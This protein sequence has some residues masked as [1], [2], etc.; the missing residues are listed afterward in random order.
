MFPEKKGDIIMG[1]TVETALREFR[2]RYNNR[3]A[4]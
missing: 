2:R 1:H 3:E 4:C